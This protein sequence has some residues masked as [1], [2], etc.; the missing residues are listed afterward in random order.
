MKRR[1]FL[2]LLGGAVAAPA[3]KVNAEAAPL[4]HIPLVAEAETSSHLTFAP[5]EPDPNAYAS[6]ADAIRMNNE[7]FARL[8]NDRARAIQ[9][10]RR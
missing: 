4:E 7:A 9:K 5:Y 6:I 3:I 1:S 8:F 2:G 10:T